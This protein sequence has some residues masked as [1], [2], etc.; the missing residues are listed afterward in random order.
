MQLPLS[1]FLMTRDLSWLTLR[2]A[3]CSLF[4]R[5]PFGDLTCGGSSVTAVMYSSSLGLLALGGF[6]VDLGLKGCFGA[7]GRR[8][9]LKK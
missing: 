5:L 9:F 1:A 7:G 3:C 2:S 4:D 8:S 6:Q